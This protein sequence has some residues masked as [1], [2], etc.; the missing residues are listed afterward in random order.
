MY[1]NLIKAARL[2]AENN[3]PHQGDAIILN[4]FFAPSS[5]GYRA[6]ITY[7]SKAG[8]EC[9]IIPEDETKINLSIKTLD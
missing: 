5:L 4:A 1:L 9:F 7:A 8:V 6:A 3:I 2:R